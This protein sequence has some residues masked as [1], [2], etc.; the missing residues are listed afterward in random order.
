MNPWGMDCN[1]FVEVVTEYLE[2]KLGE[3]DRARFEKHLD[4]CEPCVVYLEQI[5]QTLRATGKLKAEDL[6]PE[7]LEKLLMVFRQWKK[8]GN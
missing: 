6:R 1:E 2:G 4:L 7:A 8:S 5:R 3:E